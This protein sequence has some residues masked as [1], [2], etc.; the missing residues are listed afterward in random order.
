[1]FLLSI[2]GESVLTGGKLTR[3]GTRVAYAAQDALIVPGTIRENILFGQE[4]SEQWYNTVLEACALNPD[5]ERMGAKDGT[6]LGEKGAA[7]SG[8]QRQR[9]VSRLLRAVDKPF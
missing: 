9:I 5:L 1:M 3:A 4:F 7:L 6:Y 2:L 8:G